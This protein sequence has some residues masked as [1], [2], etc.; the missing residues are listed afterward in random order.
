[1]HFGLAALARVAAEKM[2]NSPMPHGMMGR[3]SGGTKVLLH[4]RVVDTNG[5]D[6]ATMTVGSTDPASTELASDSTPVGMYLVQ[7]HGRQ[8]DH[9]GARARGLGRDAGRA[10]EAAAAVPGGHAIEQRR[11]LK[12]R[13]DVL[14]RG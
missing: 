3:G 9:A 6:M 13:V 12:T 11:Q 1:M 4:A 10:G 7:K 8:D 14:V 2:H 5:K